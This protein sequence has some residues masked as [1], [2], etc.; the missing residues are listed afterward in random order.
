MRYVNRMTGEDLDPD[1]KSR[2][3]RLARDVSFKAQLK[4]VRAAISIIFASG[5]NEPQKCTS[6]T[7]DTKMQSAVFP[8]PLLLYI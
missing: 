8:E 2:V 3:G 5:L 6:P 1:Y 7:Y 4:V